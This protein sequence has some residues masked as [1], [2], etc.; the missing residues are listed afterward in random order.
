MEDFSIKFWKDFVKTN[1]DFTETCVIKNAIDSTML[2]ELNAG[3][4]NG[5]LEEQIGIKR[6]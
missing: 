3:M 1:R 4:Y 2:D 5:S 6:Y